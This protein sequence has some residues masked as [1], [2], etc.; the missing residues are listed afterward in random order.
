MISVIS[1]RRYQQNCPVQPEM[2]KQRSLLMSIPP[3]GA[4]F[5]GM[6]SYGSMEVGRREN[7]LSGPV[8]RLDKPTG[9][10]LGMVPSPQRPLPFRP[11]K[12]I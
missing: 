2:E 11:A 4:G 6:V 12:S 5:Q 8:H 9:I 7:A 3:F 1:P 10:S